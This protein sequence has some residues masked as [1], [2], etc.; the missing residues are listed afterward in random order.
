MKAGM[1]SVD[2]PGSAV[3][4]IFW[5]D[6]LALPVRQIKIP[7]DIGHANLPHIREIPGRA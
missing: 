7:F 4:R 3:R 1:E 6:R 2:A 5:P